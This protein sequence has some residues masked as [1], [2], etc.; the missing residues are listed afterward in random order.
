M[1]A[2]TSWLSASWPRSGCGG[3]GDGDG[4]K[5]GVE[6]RMY[7]MIHD[8]I[9][10][11]SCRRSCFLLSSRGHRLDLNVFKHFLTTFNSIHIGKSKC[12]VM[13]YCMYVRCVLCIV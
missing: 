8:S 10:S 12:A 9:F 4:A 3:E 7:K 11:Q 13:Y 5:C 1:L 2:W 6:G